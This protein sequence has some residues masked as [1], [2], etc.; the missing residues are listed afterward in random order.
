MKRKKG[1]SFTSL[2]QGLDHLH[3]LVEQGG[4]LMQRIKKAITSATE[5]ANKLTE[6]TRDVRTISFETQR[7]AINA[8]D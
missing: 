3:Q 6:R 2:I 7:M 5:T 4:K 1:D 8:G